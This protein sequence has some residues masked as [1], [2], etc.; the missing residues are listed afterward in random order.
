MVFMRQWC[1]LEMN[2]LDNHYCGDAKNND[3]STPK[4]FLIVW[5]EAITNES[6]V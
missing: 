6:T 5:F 1:F 4:G 2:D 3:S